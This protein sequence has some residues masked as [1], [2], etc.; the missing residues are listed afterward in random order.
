VYDSFFFDTRRKDA[1]SGVRVDLPW[2]PIS[3]FMTTFS[4]FYDETCVESVHLVRGKSSDDLWVSGQDPNGVSLLLKPNLPSAGRPQNAGLLISSIPA[5]I[6]WPG[7]LPAVLVAL[8]A[9]TLFSSYFLIRFA[10]RRLFILD[11]PYTEIQPPTI[12]RNYLVLSPPEFD[13]QE[14]FSDD[15]IVHIQ[16]DGIDNQPRRLFVG[17]GGYRCYRLDLSNISTDDQWRQQTRFREHSPTDGILLD[18]F[19]FNKDDPAWNQRKIQLVERLLAEK[20]DVVIVSSADPAT[21]ALSAEVR[22][23]SASQNGA[24]PKAND[25]AQNAGSPAATLNGDARDAYRWAK[26]LAAFTR[27]NIFDTAD[28]KASPTVF[29]ALR[30]GNRPLRYVETLASRI[31]DGLEPDQIIAEIGD[32]ASSY[33]QA[34]WSGCTKS[35]KLTL[36]YLAENGLVSHRD[37]DVRH[38]IQRGLITR[39]PSLRVVD[40]SFRR[41]VLERCAEKDPTAY[42]EDIES[43]WER[44]RVPLL[45]IVLGVVAFLF[46]TQKEFYDSTLTLLSALT[47]GVITLFRLAGMFRGKGSTET[48]G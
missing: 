20:K 2:D 8:L 38:L 21:F 47:G 27:V 34:L 28:P 42:R 45:L 37:P 5:F 46:V 40:E 35:E 12:A 10:A 3:W 43:T 14:R 26:V 36:Y 13:R 29:R 18:S 41:F 33:H 16:V 24:K 7:W 9:G 1:G 19:E 44:F 31:S 17:D 32:Q 25:G 11:L 4:P 30:A 39:E 48:G 6:T 22:N 23:K 15:R